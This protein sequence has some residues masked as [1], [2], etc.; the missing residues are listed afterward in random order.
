MELPS[1]E[2]VTLRNNSN[3]VIIIID[4]APPATPETV[5]RFRS[6]IDFG[7]ELIEEKNT[8]TK[9]EVRKFTKIEQKI[10][11]P[12]CFDETSENLQLNCEHTFCTNCIEKWLTENSNTCPLCKKSQ[13]R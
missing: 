7:Y 1:R 5:S 3:R 9:H 8:L 11:C 2:S 13:K 4:Y 10:D 12:I 6:F